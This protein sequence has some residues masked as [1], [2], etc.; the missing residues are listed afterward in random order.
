MSTPAKPLKQYYGFTRLEGTLLFLFLLFIF[1]TPWILTRDS[2][3]GFDFEDTGQIGD[4][5]GGI[6]AP[7]VNLLAAF[8]VYKSFSAQIRANKEQREQHDEQINLIINEQSINF[9]L[10]LF[11]RMKNDYDNNLSETG[12]Y[13]GSNLAFG[14]DKLIASETESGENNLSRKIDLSNGIT[15]VNNSIEKVNF[16]LHN[17]LMLLETSHD[18]ASATKNINVLNAVRYTTLKV[19]NF[20]DFNGYCT[21]IREDIDEWVTPKYFNKTVIEDIRLGIELSVVINKKIEDIFL[22]TIENRIN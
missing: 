20:F 14:F 6:T 2:F 10:K 17:F 3:L 8:L 15:S 12:V 19:R 4:T 21:L 11:D 18:M 7:F 1:A 9:L 22:L 16:T 5:I 13:Y